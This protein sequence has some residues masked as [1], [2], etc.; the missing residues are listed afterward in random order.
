M[1][2]K[3]AVKQKAD[4]QLN[5]SKDN[6]T[7]NGQTIQKKR[8]PAFEAALEAVANMKETKTH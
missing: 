2:T 5:N 8:S 1:K 7:Q 3:D 4:K 6:E